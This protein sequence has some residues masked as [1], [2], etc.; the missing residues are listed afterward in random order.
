MTPSSLSVLLVGIEPQALDAGFADSPFGPYALAAAANAPAA[1]AARAAQDF[2]AMLIDVDRLEDARAL[3]RSLARSSALVV[4]AG[5]ADAAAVVDWCRQQAQDVVATAELGTPALAARLRAANERK[6]MERE[7]GKAWAT[8]LATGLPHRQQ[9]VEHMSHLL[10][11]REREPAPMAVVAL[12]IEGFSTTESR[13]GARAADSLRRK[14]AV[15]LRAAVRASDVVAAI[16][17]ETYAV[18]LGALLATSDG[19]RVG[20]KL[21]QLLMEPFSVGGV[22]VA[23]AVAVGIGEYPADGMQPEALLRKAIGGALD[24]P[25]QGRVGMANFQETGA[26]PFPAANDE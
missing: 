8:D 22:G 4:V 21:A 18:L 7:A 24:E 26:Q 23:V 17:D 25:A 1:L 16:D 3:V 20:A 2:D 6:R 19:Q 13:L 9:L 15:R 5:G 11:L 14:I 12:R 10:A